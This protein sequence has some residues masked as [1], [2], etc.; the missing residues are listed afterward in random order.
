[1]LCRV[2]RSHDGHMADLSTA[3][4]PVVIRD[5][6]YHSAPPDF[7]RLLRHHRRRADLTQEE[8]AERA[9]LSPRSIS[10]LERGGP[11]VPRRATVDLLV[12]ALELSSA[13]QAELEATISRRR[14]PR[15]CDVELQVLPGV[16]RHRPRAW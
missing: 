11:H 4:G 8:L 13:D 3:F 16:S 10:D 6:H 15:N 12:C 14:G 1:M 9:G 2:K 5:E 7:G